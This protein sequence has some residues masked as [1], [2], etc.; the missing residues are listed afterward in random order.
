M[1][2]GYML[3]VYTSLIY[4]VNTSE[5][6]WPF[7]KKESFWTYNFCISTQFLKLEMTIFHKLHLHQIVGIEGDCDD[8]GGDAFPLHSFP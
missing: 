2:L 4:I 1:R 6:L 5:S 3:I 8:N 7:K